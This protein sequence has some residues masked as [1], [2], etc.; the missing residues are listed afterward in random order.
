MRILLDT[1]VLVWIALNDKRLS[2]SQRD[3]IADPDN[4]LLI[5]SVVAYELTHLQR[6]ARI[7]LRESI[8]ELE[9]LIGFELRDLPSSVWKEVARLPDI[10][11]DP[12]DRM[13]IAHAM[14]EGMTLA[15]ADANVRR[16]PVSII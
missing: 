14:V 4:A 5:S 13:L 11:R 3:A 7:P 1:H 10:H 8:D 15:T 12:V 9:Q 2:A 16:Y 6:C